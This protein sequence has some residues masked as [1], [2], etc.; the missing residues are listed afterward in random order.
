MKLKIS[1]LFLSVFLFSACTA[2]KVV[3]PEK[4]KNIISKPVNEWSYED[5]DAMISKFTSF[6]QKGYE[7]KYVNVNY[8][9]GKVF[10]KAVP[11]NETVIQAKIRKEAIIRRYSDDEYRNRLKDELEFYTNK[12]LNLQ[13]GEV[14]LNS[15]K[16]MTETSFEVVFE[17][18]SQPREPIELEY[19][20]EGFF[21][22][23]VN[24]DFARVVD[25]SGYYVEDYFVLIDKLKAVITFSIFDDN[26]KSIFNGSNL[27]EGYRLVFNGFQP[28]PIVVEWGN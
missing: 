28:E 3:T 12:T 11:L 20:S 24:G 7:E 21:L 27:T 18:I 19:A 4:Y 13:S 16:G 14:I 1:F 15:G 2:S 6:D 25:M 5:C 26:D 8:D 23:N 17:N 22:E 9:G 10:I